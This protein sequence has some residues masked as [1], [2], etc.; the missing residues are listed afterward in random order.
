MSDPPGAILTGWQQ[1]VQVC[2]DNPGVTILVGFVL[3]VIA[4]ALGPDQ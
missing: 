1:A 3:A 4:I 2:A